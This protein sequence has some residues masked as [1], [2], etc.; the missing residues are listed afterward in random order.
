MEKLALANDGLDT[1][2][3]KRER[4]IEL[5]P[6]Y[7]SLGTHDPPIPS[8]TARLINS[9][10]PSDLD[11]APAISNGQFTSSNTAQSQPPQALHADDPYK[12]S[13]LWVIFS[14]LAAFTLAAATVCAWYLAWA[15]RP[16]KYPGIEA[17]LAMAGILLIA[18][19][20]PLYFNYQRIRHS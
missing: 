3:K 12:S 8:S 6:S 15:I 9:S 20:A 7:Q 2:Y 14:I 10:D 4:S 11:P 1:R 18:A 13:Q 17:G 16:D 19:A 5:T